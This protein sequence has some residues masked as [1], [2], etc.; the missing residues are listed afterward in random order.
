MT[1]DQHFDAIIVGS[2]FG[3]SVM[4]YRLAEAGKRVCVM[5][6]GKPYPPGSFPRSPHDMKKNFWDPSRGLHGMFNVWS[7]R[8]LGG[9][10]SSG[11]GG[12]SLIYA[13][14]FIRKDPRWFVKEDL[15][16]GGFE[17]WPI[18]REDLEPHY[19]SVERIVAPQRFPLDV[20]PYAETAKTIALR[21]AAAALAKRHPGQL[22]WELPQLAVTFAN[23]GVPPVPGEPIVE[24]PNL[25]GRTRTT[26]RL[27]AECDI[28]CNYGS[29]NTLD[30]NYL[31]LAQNQGAELRTR[32]EVRS[33]KPRDGSG[34]EVSFV[35]HRDDTTDTRSLPLERATC[36][37]LILSA[38][39]FGS[40][41][42][43][44]KNRASFPGLSARL[45]HAFSGNGD[46]LGFA[47]DAR[48][49]KTGNPRVID[50]TTGTVITSTLR[51]ADALDGTGSGRGFYLQD[52]GLPVL[53]AWL[54]EAG[55]V[56]G[57]FT[58]TARFVS[59]WIKA[60]FSRDPSTDLGPQLSAL[61][62]D[63]RLTRSMLPLLGMGREVPD[64]RLYLSDNGYLD[65]DWSLDRSDAYYDGVRGIMG[66]IA[67]ELGA[68]YHDDPL[69]FLRRSITVHPLGGCPMG[70][71]AAQG[72]VD[73]FG[74]VFGYPGLY[75]ADG[76][77][78]PGPVGPNPSFTIAACADRFASRLLGS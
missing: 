68:K 23:R 21:D 15:A 33:F 72:V 52:A 57:L 1:P 13:N 49:G 31:T 46:I 17:S 40:T 70:E 16:G 8:N 4:A 56:P 78:L 54:A 62:G 43:M 73:P 74:Q 65:L 19:D 71:T 59:A 39:A 5:E 34:Y 9:V 55:D 20:K 69:W 25:H 77:V 27:C 38:G 37:H 35:R 32:T 12:G 66:E 47:T 41:F 30:Y 7:F 2:G 51:M 63:G 6:R 61:L 29:K 50:P 58:R 36:A 10:V 18:S 76:S 11:L 28:G 64:G 26:C 53:A 45:G 67:R 24:G 48:D 44:L 75:V 14:V 42:L 22:T 3:G 60:R